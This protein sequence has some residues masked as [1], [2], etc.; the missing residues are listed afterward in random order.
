MSRKT[1]KGGISN[2]V[3]TWIWYGSCRKELKE[4]SREQG[5]H[6]WGSEGIASLDNP[7]VVLSKAYA[8]LNSAGTLSGIEQKRWGF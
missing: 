7:S 2:D 8:I 6:G 4:A 1:K 5:T 3:Q